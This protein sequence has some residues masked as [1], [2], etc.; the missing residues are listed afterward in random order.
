MSD[1]RDESLDLERREPRAAFLVLLGVV[2]GVLLTLGVVQAGG[3]PSS[4]TGNVMAPRHK[5][6]TT[7]TSST[8][9]SLILRQ[10]I[11]QTFRAT[12]AA[13]DQEDAAGFA[14]ASLDCHP[15][16]AIRSVQYSW[17]HD[18]EAMRTRFRH[19]VE[20]SGVNPTEGATA[21]AQGGNGSSA[22][23]MP[24]TSTGSGRGIHHVGT[25]AP[26]HATW[27]RVLCYWAPDNR[28]VVEWY[29]YDTHIYAWALT[30][31]AKSGL[32]FAW[33]R[34]EAGPWHPPMD[35]TTLMEGA[36]QGGHAGMGG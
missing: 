11:P 7:E 13:E 29:D 18:A 34:R 35:M 14:I 17:F 28:A 24:E 15:G 19:D 20:V 3:P 10:H 1:P 25:R 12:C 6:A 33:W 30:D 26:A 22:Y 5:A 32:L 31:Q 36:G 23:W 4:A 27:G 21:C 2:L 16:G 8:D 9:P